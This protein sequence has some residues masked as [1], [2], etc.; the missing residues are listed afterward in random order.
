MPQFNN[1]IMFLKGMARKIKRSLPLGLQRLIVQTYWLVHRLDRYVLIVIYLIPAAVLRLLNFRV[2]GF[3]YI[4][5]IGHLL[6]EPDCYLKEERLGLIPKH[7]VIMLA[8]KQQVANQAVLE[9]WR[10]YFI[11]VTS[12]KIARLLYPLSWHPLTRFDTSRYVVA[13]NKTADLPRIQALW[14][15]RPPLLKTNPGDARRGQK[16][17]EKLGVPSGTWFVCIHSREGGYSPSDEHLHSFRNSRIEDYLMAI[18]HIISLGGMCIMMGDPTMRP[19]PK[20][21]GLIDYAHHPLR[22]DWLDLY[23]AA[24]C[25]FFLGSAS[26]ALF[27]SWVF[28]VPVACANIAPLSTVF[29][30]GQKDIGIPKLYKEKSTGRLLSFKEIMDSP[31]S[32]YR[33]SS[34]FNAAGIE[35]VN[36]SPEEIRDLAIE[37]F[38]RSASPNFVYDEEDEALQIRFREL[39]M[40]GHYMYGSASRIGRAFLKRYQ[41]LL[42]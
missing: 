39:F 34:E 16:A 24:H 33:F 35:L 5:R 23:I 30:C 2:P 36:N 7:R 27:M 19:A 18:E 12:S 25:R 29:P 28:G 1:I 8:P 17:L 11:V 38:E 9:Y 14:A 20:I 42:P 32:S 6:A 21:E 26:G 31:A 13:M 40:P 22:S 3:C 41:H 10:Q 37:Q 4:D 15:D